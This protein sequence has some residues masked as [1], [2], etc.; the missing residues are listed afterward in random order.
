MKTTKRILSVLLSA[1]MLLSV[2]AVGFAYAAD[3]VEYCSVQGCDGVCEWRVESVYGCQENRGLICKLCGNKKYGETIYNH[4]Y[5]RYAY[6]APTCMKEGAEYLYCINEDCYETKVEILPADPSA[7]SFGEWN[8][9]KEATCNKTG[10]KVAYCKNENADGA[11]CGYKASEIIPVDNTAHVFEG[12]WTRR[13]APTCE[14]DGEAF[15]ICE[16]CNSAEETK[17]LPAHSDTWSEEEGTYEII[18]EPT[19]WR[20][21]LMKVVCKKCNAN[22]TKAIPIS[23]THHWDP[24]QPAEGEVTYVA[25]TCDEDGYQVYVCRFHQENEKTEILPATG[26]SFTDYKSDG[27]AKCG[28]DGTKTAKCDNCSVT[29]TVTDEGSALTHTE[30][31]WIIS[32]GD[33]VNGGK[34]YI[35]C[36]YC[37]AAMTAEKEFSS[38]AHINRTVYKIMPTCITDGYIIDKCPDCDK[39][40]KVEYP[41]NLKASHTMEEKWTKVKDSTCTEEGLEKRKCLNCTFT[42]SRVIPQKDHTFTVVMPEIPAECLKDGHTVIRYCLGCGLE[43]AGKVLPALGH[44]DKNNDGMCD[45]C[46]I[47]FVETDSGEIIECTC[48]CHNPDGLSGLL[49]KIVNFFYQIFGINQTCECGKVHYEGN[50]LLGDLF[51]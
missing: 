20:E 14:T 4:Q 46:Y 45:R 5:Q 10:L 22:G 38:N 49:F 47:H 44:L 50:G 26:H 18:K 31:K 37:K 16:V 21:G 12:E 8:V 35:S 42:E 36:I 33:C 40:F 51:G 34:A 15:R 43:E 3:E 9:T 23:G 28:V 6:V 13:T 2:T 41:D 11:V 25:P 17:V 27:N 32:S 39:V 7:H 29:E 30:G 1:V 24:K 48:F 19:C